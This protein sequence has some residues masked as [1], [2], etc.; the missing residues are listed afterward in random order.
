[1]SLSIRH[2]KSGECV[3]FKSTK[4]QFGALSNMA[5]NF[6]IYINH[7]K[8][9]TSEALYQALRFPEY[10]DIQHQ[11]IL[12]KSPITAKKFGRQYIELTRKDW[13]QVR[14]KIMKFCIEVK[15]YQNF[16]RFSEVLLSTGDYPIVEYSDKDKVWGATLQ[17][18]YYV[19]TNALGRYLMEL[20]QRVRNSTFSLTEPN[21]IN[22][23]ILDQ[24]IDVNSIIQYPDNITHRQK[25]L[26]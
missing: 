22:M 25:M 20:R 14:F 12:Y 9:R 5:P 11:I 17:N 21:V 1:M 8:F 2:Y 16:D 7:T 26:F 19:G 4:G 10:P 18:G 24:L 13:N 23:K 3:T 15:L 6:P